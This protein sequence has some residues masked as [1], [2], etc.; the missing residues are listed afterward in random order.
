MQIKLTLMIKSVCKC[1]NA[2]S[3]SLKWKKVNVV[4]V[5]KK[6]DK[7]FKTYRPVSMLPI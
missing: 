6:V 1:S 3:F 5:Y 2:G 4:P 7:C